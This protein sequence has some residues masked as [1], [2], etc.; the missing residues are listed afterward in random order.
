MKF[1]ATYLFVS[2]IW[3][4]VSHAFFVQISMCIDFRTKRL[5]LIDEISKCVVYGPPCI[6]RAWFVCLRRIEV[7]E[8]MTFRFTCQLLRLLLLLIN[9]VDAYV[10][11]SIHGASRNRNGKLRSIF[12]GATLCDRGQS[13]D[14]ERCCGRWCGFLSVTSSP[15]STM[16]TLFRKQYETKTET[17]CRPGR[18]LSESIIYVV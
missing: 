17:V 5:T 16:Y 1:G 9:D 3:T 4:F 6:G 18:F 10:K 14:M 8:K 2:E 7:D 12:F 15:S 13:C 11:T